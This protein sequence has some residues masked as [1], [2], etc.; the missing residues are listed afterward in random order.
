VTSSDRSVEVKFSYAESELV[1][2]LRDAGVSSRSFTAKLTLEAEGTELNTQTL[3]MRFDPK[4]D[5][6]LP[7]AD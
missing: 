5:S 7:V 2:A 4:Q 1:E 3:F 6:W